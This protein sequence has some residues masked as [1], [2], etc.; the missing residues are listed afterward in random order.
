MPPVRASR[1]RRTR[2]S[3]ETTP[4]AAAAACAPSRAWWPWAACPKLAWGAWNSGRSH[5]VP[6]RH[7]LVLCK[8]WELIWACHGAK[9]KPPSSLRRRGL[10][11]RFA[12]GDTKSTACLKYTVKL[13]G[14]KLFF[15]D[16]WACRLSSSQRAIARSEAS[17]LALT[18]DSALPMRLATWWRGRP[19][20]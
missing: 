9:R 13:Y 5:R 18:V 15:A 8:V 10:G 20:T 17:R 7:S 6:T 4:L 12:G 11:S 19:F 3:G 2:V 16:A 14:D 1:T